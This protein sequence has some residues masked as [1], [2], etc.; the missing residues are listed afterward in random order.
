MSRWLTTFGVVVV[1][2]SLPWPWLQ[3][4][5]LQGLPGDMAVDL[6][7][8]FSFYLPITTSL[9]LSALIAGALSLFDR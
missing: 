8:G 3:R 2:G 1:A 6:V 7:P 9:L 4:M 5:G